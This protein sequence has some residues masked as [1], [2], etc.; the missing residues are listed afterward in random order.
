MHATLDDLCWP[1]RTERLVL[2]RATAQD[3]DQVWR[4][5]RLEEVS[6]YMTAMLT[7][8]EQ[9]RAFFAEPD[10]LARTLVVELDDRPGVI[11]GDLMV[12]VQDAW[13]QTEVADRATG[14]QAEIG[15][16]FDPAHHGH[17]YA[18]EASSELLRL[19]F[20]DLGVRRVE[21]LCFADNEPSW[22]LMERL[23][24][25]REIHTIEESLHRSGVWMDGLGY[26]ILERE[27][28]GRRA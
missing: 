14:T 20:D 16:A 4:Y 6:R 1:V 23:G 15:W 10:R 13:A 27:W 12:R 26:A 21:A 22:R 11:V 9:F 28:R 8:R 5:R 18:T 17:G 25:R 2:R 24:M 7:D 19:C 3:S